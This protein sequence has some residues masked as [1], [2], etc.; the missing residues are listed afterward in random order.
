MTARYVLHP[1][2]ITAE[3]G[4]IVYVGARQLARLYGVLPIDCVVYAEHPR[5]EIPPDAVDLW[6][7]RD[8]DYQLP[9]GPR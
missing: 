4:E 2:P 3:G 5:D 8:G 9:E 7:Q 1:G 6:P